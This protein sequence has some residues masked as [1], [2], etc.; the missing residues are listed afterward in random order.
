MTNEIFPP[1][2]FQINQKDL[3]WPSTKYMLIRDVE[4]KEVCLG[5]LQLDRYLLGAN[6][7]YDRDIVFDIKDSEVRIYDNTKC[8][9]ESPEMGQYTKL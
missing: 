3:S 6:W 5:V 8:L 2:Y 7:M 4:K 9:K 1:L